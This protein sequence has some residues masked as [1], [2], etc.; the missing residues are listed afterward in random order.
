MLRTFEAVTISGCYFEYDRP[1]RH[2]YQDVSAL[3]ALFRRACLT[4]IG[5]QRQMVKRQSSNTQ[6]SRLHFVWKLVD[7]RCG[8]R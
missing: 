5:Q 8:R 4:Q 1:D 7:S 6:L 3:L 2:R